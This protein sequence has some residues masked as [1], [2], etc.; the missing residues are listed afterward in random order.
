[1]GRITH[2]EIHSADPSAAVQFYQHVLGWSFQ[3]WG[4]PVEY[5]LIE[6]GPAGEPGINGGLLLRHGVG[7]ADG[8]AVN[9]FVCTAQVTDLD[10]TLAKGLASGGTVALPKHAVP[11]VGW[12]AYLKDLD[13]NIFGLIQNDPAAA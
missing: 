5:W 12:M 11:G 7:P 13:G 8:Q 3:K 1:M 2:F 4:G 9:A 6:T 10:D